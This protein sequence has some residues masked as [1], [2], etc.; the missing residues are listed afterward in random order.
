MTDDQRRSRPPIPTSISPE[1]QQY[2]STPAPFGTD[3]PPHDA[4]DIDGWLTYIDARN[5]VIATRFGGSLAT[6][7]MDE[8]EL[9]GVR[10]YVVRPD[11]AGDATPIYID[12][13]GGG[14]IL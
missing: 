8:M 14:L 2:L 10:T 7:P 5:Q 12:I 6:F 4:Q 9:D 3:V 1:A 11:D 13:H